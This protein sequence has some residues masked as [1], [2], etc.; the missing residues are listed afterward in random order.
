MVWQ[1]WH[2]FIQCWR[3]GFTC[4]CH[5]KSTHLRRL[6]SCDELKCDAHQRAFGAVELEWRF[7]L[8]D[9]SK[10][11]QCLLLLLFASRR[12]VH[13]RWLLL[14]FPF[15][16]LNRWYESLWCIFV[17]CFLCCFNE[18]G[19]SIVASL[20]A[21]SVKILTD[22][23]SESWRAH[24]IAVSSAIWVNPWASCWASITW[25]WL[26]SRCRTTA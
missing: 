7:F 11:H 4:G 17:P 5:H 23:P 18:Q 3:I 22:C 1:M 14:E 25:C 16:V 24:S 26:S 10:F 21:E 6:Y 9:F 15:H 2:S 19:S 8:P 20:V 12:Y 13:T